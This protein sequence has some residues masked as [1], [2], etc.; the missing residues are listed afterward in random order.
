[1]SPSEGF[2]ALWL[3]SSDTSD[4]IS[5]GYCKFI[6]NCVGSVYSTRLPGN[7]SLLSR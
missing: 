3:C 7:I 2:T 5:P 1:M 4:Q 6:T